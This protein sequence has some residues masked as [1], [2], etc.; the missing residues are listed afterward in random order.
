MRPREQH[1]VLPRQI[2]SFHQGPCLHGRPFFYFRGEN[3]TNESWNEM[4]EFIEVFT[5]AILLLAGIYIVT[6]LATV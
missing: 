6:V 2:D 4:V 3:M 1:E 5:E